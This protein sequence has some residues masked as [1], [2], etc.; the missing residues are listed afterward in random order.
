[1]YYN[2]LEQTDKKLEAISNWRNRKFVKLNKKIDKVILKTSKKTKKVL[3]E[4]GTTIPERYK[5]K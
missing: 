5:T 2:K 4:L 1:M 3:A